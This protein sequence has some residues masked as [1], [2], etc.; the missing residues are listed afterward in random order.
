MSLGLQLQKAFLMKEKHQALF[1]RFCQWFDR[2]TIRGWEDM[3]VEWEKDMS[4]KNP[5][6]EPATSM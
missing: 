5:F 1:D 6:Q 3:V 2:A 4:K